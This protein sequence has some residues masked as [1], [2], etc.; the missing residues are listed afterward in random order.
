[1]TTL[2][3]NHLRVTQGPGEPPRIFRLSTDLDSPVLLRSLEGYLS[4]QGET[5]PGFACYVMTGEPAKAGGDAWSISLPQTFSYLEGGDVLR[6]TWDKGNVE[7]LFQ[8]NARHHTFLLTERCNHYCL[9]CSQP[10]RNVQ[11]GWIVDDILEA[12]PLIDRATPEILFTGGEPTLLGDRLPEL[13]R[14]VKENLP[15]TGLHILT[16]GRTFIDPSFTAQFAAIDHHDLMFGIP[17]YSDQSERHDY[18]VQ[19]D[20]A[21]DETIRGVVNLKRHGLK[22]EIRVV[23]HKQSYERLPQLARFIARNLTFVDQV[24]FMGLEMTGFTKANLEAL[25]IDPLDYQGELA[26]AVHFLADSRIH[27]A[28]YNHQLCLVDRSLWDYARQ[29]I[30][31]WKNEYLAKCEGCSVKQHCGGFFASGKASPSRGISPIP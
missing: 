31:D 25:W 23:I 27:V 8:R 15:E 4:R 7:T 17:I 22:V 24:V 9:M 2:R 14:H 10:P 5:P 16:N 1:M 6:V 26:E 11:D 3:G 19:A 12:I 30:S 18:I 20:G 29:S 13:V 21:F 28:I